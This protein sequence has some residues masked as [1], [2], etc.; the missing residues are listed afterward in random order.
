MAEFACVIM[1]ERRRKCVAN[2]K[3]E[4]RDESSKPAANS[5]SAE[6]L[7]LKVEGHTAAAIVKAIGISRASVFRVLKDA[8]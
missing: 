6:V 4:G 8:P 7:R 1:L 2:A 5:K 3:A